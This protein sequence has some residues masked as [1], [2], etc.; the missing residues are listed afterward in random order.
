MT[1]LL[2]KIQLACPQFHV[3]GHGAT[4]QVHSFVFTVNYFMLIK[5]YIKMILY[6]YLDIVFG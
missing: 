4:C 6:N 3:Y 1:D 2:S 5:Q